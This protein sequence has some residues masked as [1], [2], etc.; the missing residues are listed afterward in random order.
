[1][2]T[3]DRLSQ[4]QR[5]ALDKLRALIGDDQID[6]IV[7]Q[8]P[9]VLEARLQ[10]FMQFEAALIGQV[11]EHVA[12]AMPTRYI[13]MPDEEPKARPLVLSV[14]AF[15][16]K[17]GENLLLW[18]REVEMAMSAAMLR[19]EQQKVGFAISKLGGRARE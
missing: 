9:E 7:A 8:G 14:K 17:E 11:H 19:T 2:E 5:Q 13:P 12:S 3:L 4:A 16:G 18:I 10:D 1:M 15:D 6:H